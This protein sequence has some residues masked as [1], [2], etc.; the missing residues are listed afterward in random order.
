MP[1]YAS[2][3]FPEAIKYLQDKISI[4]TNGWRDIMDAE[5]D[6]SF[7][8]AGAKGSLLA[9]IRSIT[10]RGITEGWTLDKFK[11]KF[12]TVAD[13]WSGN[14]DWRA[15]I[16]YQTNLRMAYSAGRYSYQLAPE[17]IKALPYMEF[18]HSDH[19]NFRP[20]HKAL[21]GKVFKA[22]Q[23]PLIVPSGYGC[24]CRWISLDKEMLGDRTVSTLQR[25]DEI[26]GIPIKPEP[27]F[28]YTPGQSS[29]EARKNMIQNIIK[30]LPPQE[31]AA[32]EAEIKVLNKR[33]QVAAELADMYTGMS[34]TE[35]RD[36]LAELE[37]IALPTEEQLAEMAALR[38]LV[39]GY[40]STN[41]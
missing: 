17:T 20:L 40:P 25:G 5:H 13:G 6:S 32:V 4:P 3:S 35:I 16:I 14:K 37:A 30:R 36:R 38:A 21:D 27:G 10:E 29:A 23:I 31:R 19:T 34:A 28:D 39:L 26:E 8:V 12:N 22:T 11:T 1:D 41:P 9:D 15:Q 18:V 7:I 33:Y 2:L 24:S